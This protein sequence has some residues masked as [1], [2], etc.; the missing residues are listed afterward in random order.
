MTLIE[1]L[2][3]WLTLVCVSISFAANVGL[4]FLGQD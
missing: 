3:A 1:L 2:R 4:W